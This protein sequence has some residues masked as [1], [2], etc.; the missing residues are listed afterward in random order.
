MMVRIHGNGLDLDPRFRDWIDTRL[1]SA[2][3]RHGSRLKHV[4]LSISD[5][6]GPKGGPDKRGR[7]VLHVKRMPTLVVEV[8]ADRPRDLVDG[9]IRR[10]VQTMDRNV[11]RQ[12]DRRRTLA[13][14]G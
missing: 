9:L 10:I 3:R 11:G 8:W 4:D 6:N 2:L 7:C 5:V 14:A 13:R 1:R 12:R